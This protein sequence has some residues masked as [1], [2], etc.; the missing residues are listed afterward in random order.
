MALAHAAERS[1]DAQYYIWHDDITGA[2][3]MRALR[4]AAERG[5]RVRL[6][7]DDNNTKGLD[8]AIAMLDAHPQ[9]RGA[10]VQSVRQPRLAPGRLRSP[11]SRG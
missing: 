4:E 2:L 9:H 7:L 8:A 5:V 11:T 10:A 3:L 1:I 6:L